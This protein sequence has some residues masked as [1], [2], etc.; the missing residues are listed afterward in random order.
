LFGF[1]VDSIRE[2]RISSCLVG[3]YVES[4]Y[5]VIWSSLTR[6]MSTASKNVCYICTCIQQIHVQYRSVV[7]V[8]RLEGGVINCRCVIFQAAHKQ[9]CEYS[10][11]QSNVQTCDININVSPNAFKQ[12]MACIVHVQCTFIHV[13]HVSFGLWLLGLGYLAY[14]DLQAKSQLPLI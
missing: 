8:Q 12:I 1:R 14:R 2:E 13:L 6:I 4:A 7:D 11:L 9:R 5:N 3:P 10:V